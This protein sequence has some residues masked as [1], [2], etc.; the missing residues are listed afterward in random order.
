MRGVPDGSFIL[1]SRGL[2]SYQ[3][4]NV[5]AFQKLL[6]DRLLL[7]SFI[8]FSTCPN[9]SCR[10]AN[11]TVQRWL[12]SNPE[13]PVTIIAHMERWR[14]KCEGWPPPPAPTEESG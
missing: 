9:P 1:T 11:G 6:D 5:S 8:H 10:E 12:L 3:F 4:Q 2:T 14:T 7:S 13:V